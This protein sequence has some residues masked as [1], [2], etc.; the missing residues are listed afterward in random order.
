[1][2][3]SGF[4]FL[5]ALMLCAIGCRKEKTY[6]NKMDASR[7]HAL[8]ESFFNDIWRVVDQVSRDNDDIRVDGCIDNITIDTLSFPMEVVIDFGDDDCVSDDGHVRKGQIHV[9]LTGRYSET[10]TVISVEPKDYSVDNYLISG[11]KRVTNLGENE[12]GN[13]HFSV[14]VIGAEVYDLEECLIIQWESS[15]FREWVSGRDTWWLN[16]DVYHITGTAS[17]FSRSGSS[18][19]VE[20]MSPLRVAW[21]CPYITKGALRIIAL[22]N[23]PSIVDYGDGNCDSTIE[24]TING[25]TY[26]VVL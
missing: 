6:N 8:A 25:E 17:G 12:N 7:D 26:T 23:A 15:R 22:N 24:V 10:G 5:A 20:I 14:E 9:K 11:K 13:I 18:F 2:K 4:L 1:M 19:V 16:D 21:P 3:R